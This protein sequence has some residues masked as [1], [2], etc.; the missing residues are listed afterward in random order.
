MQSFQHKTQDIV[1]NFNFLLRNSNIL[2][3]YTKIFKVD[4]LTKFIYNVYPQIFLQCV[5]IKWNGGANNEENLSAKETSSQD[6]ARL[7]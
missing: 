6:G 7:P 2:T 4:I 1:E 5:T 3:F